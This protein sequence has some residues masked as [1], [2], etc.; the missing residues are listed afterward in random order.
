MPETAVTIRCHWDGLSARTAVKRNAGQKYGWSRREKKKRK[1][2][3]KITATQAL[4]SHGCRV[5]RETKP[6]DAL[7]RSWA[8][9]QRAMLPSAKPIRHLGTLVGIG[10]MII[11][12]F[13]REDGLVRTVAGVIIIGMIVRS[14][15][16]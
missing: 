12:N 14:I 6:L 2:R 1:E 10:I 7:W 8:D 4:I 15:S 5:W 11:V 3:I 16:R 9:V 13:A